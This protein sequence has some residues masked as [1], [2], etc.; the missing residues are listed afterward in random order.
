M[1]ALALIIFMLLTKLKFSKIR[2]NSKVKV[3]IVG[4]Q[5]KHQSSRSHC[6]KVIRKLKVF[7][8]VGQTPRSQG[9]NCWYP[10]I[11]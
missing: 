4:T 10:L 7:K 1:K 9:Q 3:T 8:K 11:D 6:S 2:S 5:V